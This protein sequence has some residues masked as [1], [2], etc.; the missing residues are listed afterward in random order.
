MRVLFDHEVFT[1]QRFG[2]IARY[3]ARL[4]AT[5]QQ[6][7]LADCLLGAWLSNTEYLHAP[8]FPAALRPLRFPGGELRLMRALALRL[9]RLYFSRLLARADFDILHLSFYPHWLTRAE[10][11]RPVVLTIHDM[12]PE[13]FPQEFAGAHKW[14]AA[15]RYWAEHADLIIAVS[16]NTRRDLL[17]IY[18]IPPQKVR[19][20]YEAADLRPQTQRPGIRLPDKYLLY[21]GNRAGYKN[22]AGFLTAAAGTLRENPELHVVCAGGGA[23]NADERELARALLTEG[24]LRQ[25]SFSEADLFHAYKNALALVYPSLYEGFGLPVLE[26]FAAGTPVIAAR[27]GSLP[28][29]AGEAALFF[30]P[31]E[32]QTLAKVLAAVIRDDGQ[33]QRLC[34]LGAGRAG[35]FSWEETARQTARV[36]S[37]LL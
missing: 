37:T 34:R 30:E 13:L 12:T 11:T 17:R 16:E 22:F 33:R 7:K 3:C 5:L 9:N 20:I 28:E 19:V 8:D 35:A 18:D 6:L 25:Y 2:G 24:R 14:L 15:K 21:V 31:N 29:I 23:L 36:Y 32:P 27:R 4:L 1:Y 26:A 10:V